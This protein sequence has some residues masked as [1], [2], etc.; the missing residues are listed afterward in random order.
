MKK[1]ERGRDRD[2]YQIVNPVKG[3]LEKATLKFLGGIDGIDRP[4]IAAD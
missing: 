4:F 2:L 3:N 1:Y